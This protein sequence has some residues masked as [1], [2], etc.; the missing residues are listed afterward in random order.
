MTIPLG[1]KSPVK[2]DLG[3]MIFKY[4]GAAL[5]QAGRQAGHR[6]DF[7]FCLKSVCLL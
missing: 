7:M 5:S 6:F 4:E 1:A 2:N 3:W